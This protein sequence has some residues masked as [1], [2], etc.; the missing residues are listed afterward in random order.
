MPKMNRIIRRAC[1]A[2]VAIA[3]ASPIPAQTI[4]AIEG[5]S[6]AASQHPPAESALRA[7][8]YTESVL[9]FSRIP[10]TEDFFSSGI[11]GFLVLHRQSGETESWQI[12]DLPVRKISVHP[13][14]NLVAAYE[15]DGFSVYRVSVWNWKEKKRLYAKRFH[16]SIMSLSWSAKG[17]YLFAGNTSLEGI[18][19]FETKSGNVKNVFKKTPGI[20]SLT[21]TGASESSMMTFGP[22]GTILY[23]DV[24]SG[25]TKANYVASAD[26]QNPAAI[27]NNLKITGV[28]NNAVV[29][30]DAM[31]GKTESSYPVAGRVVMASGISDKTPVWFESS[32][33]DAW[34][35][36]IGD[37]ASADF[38]LPDGSAIVSALG[39][40]DRLVVGTTAGTVFMCGRISS[41]G[42]TVSFTRSDVNTHLPIDD[43]A[44]DGTRA[45]L[46]ANG[47]VYISSGPGKA[48]VFAFTGVNADRIELYND[49][50]LCWSSRSPAPLMQLSFDGETKTVLYQP[51]NE[52]GHLVSSG[53]AI[54]FIDGKSQAVTITAA[55][56][57][58][59][60]FIYTGA[61]LQ[62]TIP[63]SADKILVSKSAT[64]RNPYPLILINT[65][66]GETVPLQI[67]A[68]L[69]FGLS[70]S[71]SDAKKLNAFI[72]HAGSTPSTEII[73]L[74]IDTEIPAASVAQ[75][76]ATYPDEDLRATLAVSGN[77]VVTNLG[78][79]S[80]TAIDLVTK[81]QTILERGYA[82]P[83]KTSFMDQFIV[84]LNIDGS[85][86]WFGAK[87]RERIGDAVMTTTGYWIEEK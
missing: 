58:A 21:L 79:A 51:K 71:G 70:Y 32:A 86:T 29:L 9:S 8:A 40:N 7:H 26:I 35:L 37:A 39:L 73:S 18:T 6:F 78:K 27:N 33:N 16:D 24:A 28:G 2:T 55:T 15:S 83:V 48:P 34:K 69:C 65:A 50:L 4:D 62:D 14:G 45:F 23:T 5:G 81:K 44:T 3:L 17:T 47:S 63:V 87:N 49:T 38:V 59:N 68:D 42:E 22:S 60:P 75:T 52:I 19:V 76:E 30:I 46:L 64:P 77:T 12:S 13:D 1:I 61:G 66:T 72:V 57:A 11:D 54:S 10:S 36:R 31:S 20:V 67:K 41:K 25:A 53:S 80:L 43:I 74:T 84:S 85:L 82:L 56:D